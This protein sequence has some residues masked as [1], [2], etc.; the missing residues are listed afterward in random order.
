MS[1]ARH[2]VLAFRI[3]LLYGA[4]FLILGTHLPYFPV[5]LDWRGFSID[6]IATIIAAPQIIRLAFTPTISFLADRSGNHR[7]VLILLA[8]GTAAS[9]VLLIWS[10]TFAAVFFVAALMAAFWTTVMPLTETAAMVGVRSAGLDYGRMRLW[11]SITFIFASF[12]GGVVVERYGGPSALWMLIASAIMLV[13]AVHLLPELEEKASKRS[14]IQQK[15]VR[16]KDAALLVS[17]P[18]FLLFIVAVSAVQA[19]HGVYYA[20]GT[21]H[22]QSL[23]ISTSAIG[24]LWGVGVAAEIAL[25]VV[26]G[27]VVAHFGPVCLIITGAL[28]TIIR[29]AATAIDPPFG[30]LIVSQILHG[31]TFGATHIGAIH[32][33][34]RAVPNHL[35]GTAQGLYATM[36]GG[37][38][39]GLSMYVAGPLYIAWGGKAYLFMSGLGVIALSAALVL[40]AVWH[41]RQL[42]GVRR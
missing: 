35:A 9:M 2:R 8:W 41:G 39:M 4:V 25:F 29:W 38:A 33:I 14:A 10:D 7:R 42:V 34:A 37:V 20:F 31:A 27:Y 36:S 32:F 22:W 13:L 18:A 6:Q 21:L 5:W 23:G 26:S 24:F 3:A 12:G 16:I 17:A 1:A 11:G 30:F 15:S 19:G 40:G 28:A